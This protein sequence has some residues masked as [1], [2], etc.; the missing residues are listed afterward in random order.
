MSE[1]VTFIVPVILLR[2]A[3]EL[4]QPPEKVR[5]VTGVP[6]CG[7]RIILMTHLLEVDCE[8]SRAH[9]E[10]RAASVLQMHQRVVGMGMEI[11]GQWHSHPS[12]AKEA[13]FPSDIDYKTARI[14]ER[15]SP[16]QGAI[17]SE[18]GR[19]VRFFNHQQR[20]Q[21]YVYGNCIR[22]DANLFEFPQESPDNPVQA[23]SS[24]EPNTVS[25]RPS[26]EDRLVGPR[27]D[28]PGTLSD[29]R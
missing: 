19:F 11:F 8:A 21:V 16:F 15:G 1:P 12:K 29:G 22:H 6:Q 18:G 20:S 25:N 7:G 2:E 17:F 23:E 3:A 27:E 26:D 28:G 14:W 10:P 4:L 24:K 13:T 9:V 5:F